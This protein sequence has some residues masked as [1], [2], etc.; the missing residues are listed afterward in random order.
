MILFSG[1]AGC[2]FQSR[3]RG[4]GRTQWSKTRYEDGKWYCMS[5]W[6]DFY[7][8]ERPGAQWRQDSWRVR[9]S[10]R[11]LKDDRWFWSNWRCRWERWYG[12]HWESETESFISDKEEDTK[13]EMSGDTASGSPVE[14]V[15]D[16]RWT[17]EWDRWKSERDWGTRWWDRDRYDASAGREA[18]TCREAA[19]Q[20]LS[21][22]KE[23]CGPVASENGSDDWP[24][25]M[26]RKALWCTCTCR[27]NER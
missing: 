27:S 15:K 18:S 4:W 3:T 1:C 6:N 5:C 11:W 16:Y 26:T 24:W 8:S 9:W 21:G 10:Q 14:V 25:P 20:S 7:D 17:N 2:G 19:T 23:E 22:V 12:G 13:T